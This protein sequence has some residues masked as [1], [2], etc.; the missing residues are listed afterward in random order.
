MLITI[1]YAVKNY[2][3]SGGTSLLDSDR[4][5]IEAKP[6]ESKSSQSQSRL[7]LQALL[8]ERFKL[9]VHRETKEML[10]YALMAGKNPAKL[11]ESSTASCFDLGPGSPPPTSRQSVPCGGMMVGPNTLMGGK[12]TMPEFVADLSSI[13]GRPVIDKTGYT[14]TFSARLEFTPEGTAAFGPG[15]FGG[16]P[17]PPLDPGNGANN[18]DSSRL[19]SIFTAI[20]EQLGL[21][22]ES[23][24]GAGEILVI[25]RAEKASEN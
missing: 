6:A 23:Q 18:V 8:E 12:I 3:I 7:R 2:Q 1:A 25:D 14:G 5:D 4:Y 19:P 10:V 11:A 16:P 9:A 22:L 24:K 21:K 20:Q 13:L 17:G 15:G